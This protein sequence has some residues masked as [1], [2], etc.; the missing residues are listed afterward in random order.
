MDYS[1]IISIS[2][3][4]E[5]N[6]IE[7]T[8]PKPE[9]KLKFNFTKIDKKKVVKVNDIKSINDFDIKKNNDN[10]I[11]EESAPPII[12]EEKIIDNLKD[13]III[14]EIVNSSK[15]QIVFQKAIKSKKTTIVSTVTNVFQYKDN[16]Y[17]LQTTEITNDN[18]NNVE[19][20]EKYEKKI[21]T[22]VIKENNKKILNISKNNY[23]LNE[24][25]V[26]PLLEVFDKNETSMEQNEIP[27]TIEPIIIS[28]NEVYQPIIKNNKKQ[29]ISNN[30]E[31]ISEV[32]DTIL[33]EKEI[34]EQ[35]PIVE[36]PIF[37]KIYK[38]P[39]IV[40]PINIESELVE[41]IIMEPVIVEPIDVE[42]N[43]VEPIIM[44]PVI[45][46][47]IDVEQNYVEPIIMEPVIIEPIKV[48]PVIV[49][50]IKVEPIIMEPERYALDT[51]MEEYNIESVDI[52][53]DNIKEILIFDKVEQNTMDIIVD[54][55]IIIKDVENINI[56]NG[57]LE[58]ITVYVEELSNE[59][60]NSNKVVMEKE[61]DLTAR[62]I[63]IE[64]DY[65]D[66][67][68]ED[69]NKLNKINLETKNEVTGFR[70]DRGLVMIN[71]RNVPYSE[72][73]KIGYHKI[74]ES[75]EYNNKHNINIKLRDKIR[76]NK[77][78][79]QRDGYIPTDKKSLTKLY[80]NK[81]K[82]KLGK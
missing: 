65:V 49:E 25:I 66:L 15:E 27:K 39:V 19:P 55:N 54:N 40:E 68:P 7:N 6:N 45:V 59:Q 20:D 4:T 75:I 53:S 73:N 1:N 14:N 80:I 11:V 9:Y 42:Q 17:I 76:Y 74:S 10:V 18:I 71:L 43:Y 12:P 70:A 28:P 47:P 82:N 16:K 60:I 2:D 58:N 31:D 29:K 79:V 5:E 8:V 24:T 26:Q 46:E 37:E 69:V 13:D 64:V 22:K 50:S 23:N 78:I 63:H 38:E 56:E 44:E 41:P 30:I 81:I 52:I 35:V 67:P 32:I 61:L 77:I 62:N 33:I 21:F 36:K 48:E 34:M 72:N 3:V 57:D 51:S